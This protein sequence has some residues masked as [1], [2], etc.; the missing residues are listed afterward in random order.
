[1]GGLMLNLQV[2]IG[3]MVLKN[4]VMPASGTFGYGEE[5][6]QFVDL[7]KLGA[8]VT[9]SV[10]LTPSQGNPPPRLTETPAGILASIGLQSVGLEKFLTEKLPFLRKFDTR[11]IVNISGDT[12]EDY[13]E[14]ARRLGEVEGLDAV[15]VNISCP[16]V[17]KG[18]MFFGIDPK[19]TYELVSHVKKATG[20]LTVITK[21]TPNVTDITEIAVAAVEAGTDALCLINSP[22]GMAVDVKRRKPKLAMIVGGL[23]GPAIRPIGVRAVWQVARKVKVPIIGVGG[24]FTADDTLEYIIAGAKAVQVGTANFV[25]PNAMIEIIE[26]IKSYME[27][28]GIEDINELVGSLKV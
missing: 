11:I 25:N 12:V 26:G 1:M 8:V 6:A 21:L 20:R 19:V 5:Y 23:C 28:Q 7:N 13:V 2:E 10:R 14:L 15:E 17:E 27:S 24:I 18:G 3:G 4:P 22:L 9:K 16:N